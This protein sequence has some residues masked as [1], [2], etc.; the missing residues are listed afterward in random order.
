MA[1]YKLVP[2]FVKRYSID[3]MNTIFLTDGCSDGNNGKIVDMESGHSHA[4]II[5][6]KFKRDY[7]MSYDK[8]SIMVDR[9]TKRQYQT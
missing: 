6:N 1:A 3:K 7:M 9:K 2:A 5:N 4:E 8:N